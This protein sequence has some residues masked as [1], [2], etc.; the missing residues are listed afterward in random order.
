MDTK[1]RQMFATTFN[2]DDVLLLARAAGA[3]IRLRGIHPADL[4]QA[5]VHGAMGDETRSIATARRTFFRIT[6]YMPEESSFY[7]R[8]TSGLVALMKGLFER[9]L[10]AATRQ[11]REAL[12]AALAGSG[13][14]DVEAIDGSQITLPATAADQFPSTCDEHGGV[15]MTATLSVLFQTINAITLT[16]ARTHDRC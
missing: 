15:K 8:F 10:A 12:A 16:D 2:R 1:L 6:G 3:V 7:D 13:L 11:Q 9:A 5:L 14:V 4:G